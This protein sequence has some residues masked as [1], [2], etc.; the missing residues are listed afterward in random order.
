MSSSE[1]LK[2]IEKQL[3]NDLSNSNLST[4]NQGVNLYAKELIDN[5]KEFKENY[6]N[7]STLITLKPLL[8]GAKDWKQYSWD[9]NS[10]I[11]TNDIAERL[12][13][14]S[15]LKKLKKIEYG[16]YDKPNKNED[17]LD[18][19]ARAL[20]QAS[21]KI[22]NLQEQYLNQINLQG[23]KMS[24][25]I[26]KETK[27]PTSEKPELTLK[28]KL[29]QSYFNY[30]INKTLE[31]HFF[32]NTGLDRE[33]FNLKE[34]INSIS[35]EQIKN[36]NFTKSKYFHIE[37][38]LISDVTKKRIDFLNQNGKEKEANELGDKYVGA[39][40]AG[41]CRKYAYAIEEAKGNIDKNGCLIKDVKQEIKE[42]KSDEQKTLKSEI[43]NS[44]P[45]KQDTN[46]LKEET[47][48]AQKHIR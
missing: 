42:K 7:E 39:Y 17:W 28:D 30:Q 10:L 32:K 29:D 8:N 21:N 9:G 23:D 20:F 37:K 35:D 38:F 47:S 48:K 44:K 40:V 43:K 27:N 34:K 16:T 46:Q 31:N 45:E 24:K 25:T 11:Y 15:T 6:P 14:Y 2:F 13:P 18:V 36:F 4:W 1:V 3:D 41:I 26:K 5:F 12:T 19:Q 33:K 22:L